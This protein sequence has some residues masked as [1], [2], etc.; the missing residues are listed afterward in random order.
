MA[1]AS[2]DAAVAALTITP[3]REKSFDFT[4]AFYTTGLGI[5]VSGKV[6]SPCFTVVK[7]FI[8]VAFLKV[9]ATLTLLLLG[10]GMLVWWFELKKNPSSS[11]VP[12]LGASAPDFGG[13][14]SH[15]YCRL[16]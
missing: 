4:H 2:L 6:Q 11:T 15:N 3:E 13:L 9:I 5:A 10:V 16:W 8:S 14:P 12:P 7:R 1:I